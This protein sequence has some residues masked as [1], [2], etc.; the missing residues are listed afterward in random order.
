MVTKEQIAAGLEVVRAVADAIREAKRIPSG[1]LYA[2]LASKGID[3]T[4]YQ[5]IVGILVRGG[6]VEQTPSHELVWL[7]A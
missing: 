3:F 4:A 7:L 5:K 1:H 2:L 6:L